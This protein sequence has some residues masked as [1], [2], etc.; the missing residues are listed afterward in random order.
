MDRQRIRPLRH[1]VMSMSICREWKVYQDLIGNLY[2]A[3]YF[4]RPVVS[5][6]WLVV[7]VFVSLVYFISIWC[8]LIP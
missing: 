1:I 8:F 2:E 7:M 6:W 3:E 5:R 4:P